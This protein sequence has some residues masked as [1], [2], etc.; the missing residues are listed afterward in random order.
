MQYVEAQKAKIMSLTNPDKKMSKS[1]N[2][3]RSRI[4][5]NDS[6]KTVQ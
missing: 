3:E 2:N 6:S 4:N 1:D 5:L